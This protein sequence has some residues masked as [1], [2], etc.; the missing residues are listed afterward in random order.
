MIIPNLFGLRTPFIIKITENEGKGIT[1]G[2]KKLL[3]MMGMFIILIA[4]IDDMI[5]KFY[6]S[7]WLGYGVQL[8]GQTLF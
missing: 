2:N 8:F 1:K 3:W 5:V 7:S 4:M 6:V